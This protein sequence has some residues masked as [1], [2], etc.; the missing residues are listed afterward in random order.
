M[1]EF[2]SRASQGAAA[3][4]AYLRGHWR[5][6]GLIA[7]MVFASALL[8]WVLGK[9]SRLPEPE[10]LLDA[11]VAPEEFEAALQEH[12]PG[13]EPVRIEGAPLPSPAGRPLLSEDVLLLKDPAPR[14]ATLRE[15]VDAMRAEEGEAIPARG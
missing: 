14:F 12:A 3:A 6:S 4:E 7:A 11:E 9:R 10:L 15:A 13:E 2:L 8:F 5:E 1:N